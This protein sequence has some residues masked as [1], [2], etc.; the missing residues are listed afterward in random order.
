MSSTPPLPPQYT[1]GVDVGT[2]SVRAGLVSVATGSIV[3]TK[4]SAIKL[5]DDGTFMC[6]SSSDIWAQVTHVVN[7][8][9]QESSCSPSSVLGISFTATCSMVC[10]SADNTGVACYPPLPTDDS[11]DIVLWA[12]HRATEQADSIN[13]TG[14]ARLDSVGGIISPSMAMPKILWLKQNMAAACYDRVANGGKFIDICDYLLYRCTD[15]AKDV[16]SEC[17]VVC[18]WS[19]AEKGW[20][21][22][23][24]NLIGLGASVLD[25]SVIGMVVEAPGTPVGKVGEKAA[26]EL[27]LSAT[28]TTLSV[29]LIDAH[30]GGLGSIGAVPAPHS[31]T[32]TM[33]LIA[34]TSA[35]HMFSNGEALKVKGVWG[36]Y[37]NAMVPGLFLNEAGQTGAGMVLDHIIETHAAFSATKAT[38]DGRGLAV[39][40]FLEAVLGDLAASQGCYVAELTKNL[41]ITPDFLGNRAPLSDP[42]LR[43]A[44]VGL[45]LGKG[46]E[47]LA[48][49]YLACVQGLA[50]GSRHIIDA[51][52][53]AG[54]PGVTAVVICGGLAQNSLYVKTH[55]DV[56]GL[57]C[58]LTQERETVVLGAAV[59]AA[60]GAGLFSNLTAAMVALTT[61]DSCV[62]GSLVPSILDYHSKKYSVYRKMI[63]DQLRY[64][65]MMN[66]EW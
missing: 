32:S 31:V 47:D 11:I 2:S 14:H 46:I 60:A 38:A 8:V 34:G 25:R 56:L 19:Y 28:T 41:H 40:E 65:E 26:A 16:R 4:T 54:H 53:T 63:D 1:I 9:I 55:A 15:Y 39:T 23:F 21:D 57:P 51:V 35:C 24:L 58:Y 37:G 33:A 13:A 64:R 17:S 50:Y 66:A 48:L 5:H 10:L 27:G 45:K 30:S 6:Q 42:T 29:G 20:D 36:P 18:K 3:N 43:G 52:V 62:S 49:K 22:S 44:W 61:V 7:A 12:D 59:V